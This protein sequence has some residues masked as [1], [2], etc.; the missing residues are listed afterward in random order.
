VYSYFFL[1]CFYHLEYLLLMERGNCRGNACVDGKKNG[2][3]MKFYERR[4]FISAPRPTNK[5]TL[6]YERSV[7]AMLN[8]AVQICV[9]PPHVHSFST[10]FPRTLEWELRVVLILLYGEVD[11]SSLGRNSSVMLVRELRS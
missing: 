9:V 6:V 3:M 10:S 7:N 2:M 11:D 4:T 5:E 1:L 8:R